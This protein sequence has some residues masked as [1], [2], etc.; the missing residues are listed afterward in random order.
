MSPFLSH[1]QIPAGHEAA[2]RMAEA[3]SQQTVGGR[4]LHLIGAGEAPLLEPHAKEELCSKLAAAM[5]EGCTQAWL[6]HEAGPVDPLEEYRKLM[7]LEVGHPA[8][9]VRHHMADS[10]LTLVGESQR[11]FRCFSYGVAA[12]V[13][14]GSSEAV[15]IARDPYTDARENGSWT[16]RRH[17]L[18]TGEMVKE[19]ISQVEMGDDEVTL[20]ASP[21]GGHPAAL[22]SKTPT[23]YS[24]GLNEYGRAEYVVV[25]SRYGQPGRGNMVVDS[26]MQDDIGVLHEAL[27][28]ALALRGLPRALLTNPNIQPVPQRGAQ[29]EN[30][31]A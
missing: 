24:L 18:L 5:V 8:Q 30:I 26:V 2:L 25:S 9:W 17:H 11:R 12:M 14:W 1:G 22:A 28:T 27:G 15:I 16:I 3:L 19:D 6:Q 10:L 23:Y 21:R 13:D 7:Y 29:L 31:P 4:V 20:Y